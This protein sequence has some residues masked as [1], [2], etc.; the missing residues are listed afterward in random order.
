METFS[1][2]LAICTGNSPVTGEFPAQRPV[3]RSFDNFFYLRLTKRFGKQSWR[4]WFETSSRPLWCH[5]NVQTDGMCS[6]MVW[7][8]HQFL[9]FSSEWFIHIRQGCFTS[10]ET[11]QSCPI[12]N[13]ITLKHMGTINW[14][15]TTAK[16][17]KMRTTCT[18]LGPD[19]S[20]QWRIMNLITVTSQWARWRLKSPA[21]RLFTQS[22][23]QTQIKE[24]TKAPRHWPL[25]GEFTGEFPHKWPVTRKMFPFH[26]VI[27]LTGINFDICMD[28]YIQALQS[29]WWNY[30]SIPKLQ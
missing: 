3:T 18:I 14:C 7:I 25:W 2:L 1:A 16:P 5:C 29:V 28:I 11:I 10:T 24:N 15:Q 6:D 9:A 30:L 4:W 26:D 22:F 20:R 13:E 17:D 8:Y 27:M 12:T 23:I 21:S 19:G